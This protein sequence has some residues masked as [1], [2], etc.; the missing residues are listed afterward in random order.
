MLSGTEPSLQPPCSP[1]LR[2]LFVF[3]YMPLFAILPLKSNVFKNLPLIHNL[4]GSTVILFSPQVLYMVGK[5][6]KSELHSQ[7]SYLFLLICFY[8]FSIY[9]LETGSHY[10][11]QAGLELLVVLLP[12]FSECWEYR[13]I[14]P[15]T[16][17]FI[18]FVFAFVLFEIGPH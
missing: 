14:L 16:L 11:V 1:D 3:M 17:L 7:L 4:P 5:C 12:Q 10:R 8:T 18:Q 2:I 15:H 13:N 9:L 6:S